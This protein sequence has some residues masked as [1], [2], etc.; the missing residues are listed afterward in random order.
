MGTAVFVGVD[1][2]KAQLD[3]AI[4][5]EGRFAAANDEKG[6]ST[7]VEEQRSCRARYLCD[8]ELMRRLV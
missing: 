2:S 4:R 3:I 1:V 8:E 5:P 6:I 7:T